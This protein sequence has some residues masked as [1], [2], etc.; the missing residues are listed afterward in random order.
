MTVETV[1]SICR[2]LPEVTEDI[3][4]GHDLCFSVGGKMF[5]VIDLERPHPVAFKC[6]PESFGEL[7]AR[8]GIIPAP[9][10]ARNMWVMEQ[11]LGEALDRREFEALVRAS[12]ELVVA[13]LPKSKQ[14]GASDARAASKGGRSAAT[15]RKATR[16]KPIPRKATPRARRAGARKRRSG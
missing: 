16:R 3:K 15:R 7:T 12:Y 4:W 2:A 14:P 5:T 9:Y 11:E 8:S 10:M 13:T 1:R 6:T